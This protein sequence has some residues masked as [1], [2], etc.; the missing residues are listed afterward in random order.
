MI[1]Y[2]KVGNKIKKIRKDKNLSQEE[3]AEEIGIS[4]AYLGQVERGQKKI[5]IKTLEKI[6]EKMDIP[7]ETLICDMNIDNELLH[8]WKLATG[9]L[10]LEEKE[11]LATAI[12]MLL[13]TLK[14]IVKKDKK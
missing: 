4:P 5:A 13:T 6:A 3:F 2:K 1:D 7:V 8:S 11:E 9:D 10:E 14:H 12:K